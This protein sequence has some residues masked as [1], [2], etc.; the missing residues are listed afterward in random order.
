MD[1]SVSFRLHLQNNTPC[2]N[3]KQQNGNENSNFESSCTSYSGQ[4]V[5]WKPS[6][7]FTCCK[8]PVQCCKYAS[9]LL[10]K[11]YSNGSILIMTGPL[12][13]PG[14]HLVGTFAPF[15]IFICPPRGNFNLILTYTPKFSRHNFRRFLAIP[16]N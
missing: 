6:K 3:S 4:L 12:Q 14:F 11:L 5:F 2:K 9:N 16:K 1:C 13:C 8:V 7:M 15:L 10:K